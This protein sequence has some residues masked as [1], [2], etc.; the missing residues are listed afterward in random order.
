M[1]QNLEASLG[2]TDLTFGYRGRL[3][4]KEID[5]SLGLGVTA[6]LGPNGAG[7]TTFIKCLLGLLHPKSGAVSLQGTE[8][9]RAADPFGY[10]PQD[11]TLPRFARVR[12]VVAY[13]GWLSGLPSE[14]T[15]AAA[16]SVLISLGMED[17]S[18]RRI[19]SLSGGQK[20]RTAVACGLV[21]DPRVLIL[22]EPTAG[23]DPGQ[24]LRVRDSISGI[25]QDGRIILLS[26]HLLEDVRHVA[27]R[28]LVLASGR[29]VFDGIAEEL[30]DLISGGSGGD[31]G[32][33]NFERGYEDLVNR[34]GA[35]EE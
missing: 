29:I 12:D 26:T 30:S 19:S 20:K 21:H 13:A 9:F 22:D 7:K 33:S 27:D 18:D 2:I 5:I 11:A 34:L 24:R 15:R 35:T 4:L 32:G 25:G 31:D 1:G 6:L 16:E 23:L 28:I 8:P 3:V 17:L 10:V 14:N